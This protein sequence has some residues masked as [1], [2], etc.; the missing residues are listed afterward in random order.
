ME[1]GEKQE[2]ACGQRIEDTGISLPFRSFLA[3]C[4]DCKSHYS[5]PLNFLRF[6]LV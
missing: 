4:D 1:E 5:S 3:E 2:I 6:L